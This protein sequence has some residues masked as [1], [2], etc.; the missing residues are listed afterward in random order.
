MFEKMI[1]F[2][3]RF[4]GDDRQPDLWGYWARAIYEAVA[5]YFIV[6]RLKRAEDTDVY[7]RKTNLT[8]SHAIALK[9]CSGGL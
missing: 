3:G 6:N 8:R 5:I 1:A 4:L 7:D 9:R 2:V